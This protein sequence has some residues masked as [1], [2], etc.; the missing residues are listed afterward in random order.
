M[1][2]QFRQLNDGWNAE[3]NAPNARVRVDGSEVVLEFDANPYR[4]PRFR[5][6]QRLSL[7]FKNAR[8]YRLGA[9]NDEGWYMGQ[10]RFSGEAPAWGQFYEVLGDR[11]LE[12]SPSDWHRV[13]KSRESGRHFLFY[14]RDGTFECEADDWTFHE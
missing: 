1:D 7:R 9:T 11:K 6:E 4:Y 2:T 12:R 14:L 13:G 5:V 3:P 10:C 8:R